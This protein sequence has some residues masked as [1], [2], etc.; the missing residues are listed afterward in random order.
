MTVIYLSPY[1]SANDYS[2][3]V[4]GISAFRY[5]DSYGGQSIAS[6]LVYF[7][8]PMDQVHASGFS[9]A[10][11]YDGVDSTLATA[12]F[13][14]FLGHTLLQAVDSVPLSFGNATESLLY[15]PLD[16]SFY[17]TDTTQAADQS[18]LY[19]LYTGNA[20]EEVL[21]VPSFERLLFTSVSITAEARSILE[22]DRP[23]PV[24]DAALYV[25]D[26]MDFAG[27]QFF[28]GSSEETL[29]FEV[30]GSCGS[31]VLRNPH[32]EDL[33]FSTVASSTVLTHGTP[34]QFFTTV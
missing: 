22:F 14:G 25:S 5:Y 33:I 8:T 21:C 1:Y 19:A 30:Q 29:S 15:V 6:S 7:S 17:T 27:D 23:S 13:T 12:T 3:P 16:R 2:L 26:V 24:N 32:E 20:S 11:W 28:A 18:D 10:S 4:Q 9:E 31:V 34:L